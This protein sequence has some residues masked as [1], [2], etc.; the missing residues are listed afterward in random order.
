MIGIVNTGT[1]NLDIYLHIFNRLDI[2]AKVIQSLDDWLNIE[3]LFIPGVGAFDNAVH[4]L[5]S[6]G[7]YTKIEDWIFSNRPTL[8]VCLGFQLLFCSSDEGV[9]QGLGFIEGHVKKFQN[10]VTP[11]I[12][13]AFIDW[14][15]E[16]SL[17]H[18]PEERFYFVH[19]YYAPITE[20]SICLA[21][22]GLDYCAGIRKGNVWGFQF[23]PEKSHEYGIALIDQIVRRYV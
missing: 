4:T 12:G 10:V 9:E 14:D 11:R 18:D 8:C 6:K 19:S 23:H 22:Y 3:F 21:H 15:H 2:E 13:W 5:E 17:T 1:G 7:L 16:Q 20:Y